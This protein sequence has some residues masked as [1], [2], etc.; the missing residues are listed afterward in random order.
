MSQKMQLREKFIQS[1]LAVIV[2]KNVS[3]TSLLEVADFMIFKL[4]YSIL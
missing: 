3:K 4:T 2:I 1:N